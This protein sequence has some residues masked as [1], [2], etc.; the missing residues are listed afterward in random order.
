MLPAV[1]QA[2]EESAEHRG[3]IINSF[4][5]VEFLL[6]DFV[7]KC[8]R[9][10]EYEEL[11]RTLPYG[12][13]KRVA[14][15]RRICAIQGAPVSPYADDIV[16]LLD[17]LRELEELRHFLS[18]GF[19]TFHFTP[20]GDI[21]SMFRRFVPTKENPLNVSSVTLR[22]HQLAEARARWIAFAEEALGTFRRVYDELGLEAGVDS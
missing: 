3:Y 1:I 16:P 18:H 15:V 13:D 8:R 22:P 20:A 6:A 11:T 21:G 19:C 2:I 7:V 12:V 17:R 14:R 4:A 9:F 10:A 5:Q